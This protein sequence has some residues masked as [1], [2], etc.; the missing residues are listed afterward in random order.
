MK[1]ILIFSLLLL[2]LNTGLASF[3]V[4]TDAELHLLESDINNVYYYGDYPFYLYLTNYGNR[5]AVILQESLEDFLQEYEVSA[6]NPAT[7]PPGYTGVFKF[8]LNNITCDDIGKSFS[9]NFNITYRS[10]DNDV[11]K[12]CCKNEY[13]LSIKNPISIRTIRPSTDTIALYLDEEEELVFD[14]QNQANLPINYY[15][16]FDYS[17]DIFAKYNSFRGMFY[18]NEL[19]E[20]NFSSEPISTERWRVSMLPVKGGESAYTFTIKD[21]NGCAN[22]N[23]TIT[24]DVRVLTHIT[25]IVKATPEISYFEILILLLCAGMFLFFKKETI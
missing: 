10:S 11:N 8:T 19:E 13:N 25:R 3:F 1:R 6:M 15:F 22:V 24:K 20:S 7:V 4:V 21:V 12:S 17:F 23:A 14:L 18:K 5:D 9:F 16:E 2:F